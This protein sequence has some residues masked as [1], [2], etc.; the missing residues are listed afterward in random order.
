MEWYLMVIDLMTVSIV[1]L[2][3]AIVGV[4]AYFEFYLLATLIMRI[5]P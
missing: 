5:V 1:V 2:A 4:I 3:A